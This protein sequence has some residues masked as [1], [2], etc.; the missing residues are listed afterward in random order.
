[1]GSREPS[2]QDQP[3][4][5]SEV[6]A[7]MWVDQNVLPGHRSGFVAVVGRPNVGKSTFMNALIGQ[8]VAI[9]SPKPQTTRKRIRGILTRP[10]AQIIF[11][12]TPGIHT[13]HHKLGE[14]M[15]ETAYRTI[16]DADVIVFMVDAS[17]WPTQEDREIAERLRDVDRP[18]ILLIN[19]ADLI[20]PEEAEPRAEAYVELGPFDQWFLTSVLE[21]RDLDAILDAIVSLLPEGPCL[22]PEEV[23]TDQTEREIVAELV[24]EAALHFL[25]QEVPHAVEVQVD[26][27]KE[28]ENGVVYIGA[29]LYV[30][31]DSQKRIV[32]GK[33]GAMLKQMTVLLPPQM[34][35]SQPTIYKQ[36]VVFQPNKANSTPALNSLREGSYER[37]GA[38]CADQ[39]VQRRRAQAPNRGGHRRVVGLGERRPSRR[40]A[41]RRSRTGT[42]SLLPGAHPRPSGRGTPNFSGS[43]RR[44]CDG[45]RD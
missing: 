18:K 17:T 22:Y 4:S 6:H 43:Y 11:L 26:E 20:A 10:D 44:E 5:E 25:K 24:R 9:V 33:G 29:T 41:S 35:S 8:K 12:D 36:L 38:H 13:P 15:V 21:G 30:E 16:P 28:R 2:P 45:R 40:G 31:R 14:I 1:M 7:D 32:I 34:T 23:I 37:G 19:K 39:R 27:F 3:P 42:L